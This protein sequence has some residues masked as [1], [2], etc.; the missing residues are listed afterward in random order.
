MTTRRS[1]SHLSWWTW[2]SYTCDQLW[3]VYRLDN[4]YTACR[5]NEKCKK[6]FFIWRWKHCHSSEDERKMKSDDR[7]L[8]FDG[9]KCA[10]LVE[11]T[12]ARRPFYVS[13][14]CVL[15]PPMYAGPVPPVSRRRRRTGTKETR[16][17][18]DRPAAKSRCR[19]IDKNLF[20]RYIVVWTYPKD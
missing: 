12:T 13:H 20:S 16:S 17:R 18:P 6:K 11:G 3:G 14:A 15:Y 4:A 19:L 10:T 8:I 1:W 7:N 5:Q 9:R 2:H